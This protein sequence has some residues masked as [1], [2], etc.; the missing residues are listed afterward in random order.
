M[1]TVFKK[2]HQPRQGQLHHRD[3]YPDRYLLPIPQN[4]KFSFPALIPNQPTV[5]FNRTIHHYPIFKL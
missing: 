2:K 1:N 5:Q 3:F 4:Y